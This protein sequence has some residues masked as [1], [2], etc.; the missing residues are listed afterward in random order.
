MAGIARSLTISLLERYIIIG[1][2]VVSFFILARLLTPKEI[3]LFSVAVAVI[4]IAQI[5]RDFGIGSYLIQEKELTQERIRTAFTITLIFSTGLFLLML[6]SANP[7]AMY[8]K[9]ER[10]AGVLRLLSINFLFIPFNTTTI[11]ILKRNM[12]FGILA[13][14]NISSAVTGT[15]TALIFAASGAG[16]NALVYSSIASTLTIVM[17][18]A[19]FRRREFFLRPSLAGWQHVVKFGSQIAFTSVLTHVAVN[20]NDLVVGRVLGFS[21][22]GILSRAQGV[23]N[24]FHRDIMTAIRNVAYPGFSQAYR[25]GGDLESIHT[26]SVTA[27]TAVA[28]PFYGFFA[29]FPLESL[30]LLFGPQ[31]DAAAPLVPVFCFA[32]AIAAIWSLGPNLIVAKGRVD[33]ITRTEI[34]IQPFRILLLVVCA[35][36]FDT[37]M[38]FALAL[39]IIY[40]LH[41]FNFY[42]HKQKTLPT[43]WGSLFKGL[44]IS[45]FLTMITLLPAVIVQ[46]VLSVREIQVSEY[47]LVPCLA[48]LTLIVWISALRLTNHPSLYDPIF[49]ESIRSRIAKK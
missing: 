45:G 6:L 15:A 1:L 2:Q 19:L 23:M 42:W 47:F 16:Y 27:L 33:L 14:F 34:I 43:E 7:V 10:L 48:F 22:V 28:W 20:I 38:P 18:G 13:G 32:G 31:W 40:S 29:L 11:A 4:G 21:A 37:L 41:L 17:A 39:L 36:F 35:F 5:L 12:Q 26:R 9:D 3:G 30:R 46:L 25:N 49:P 24:I 8:Y 44:R